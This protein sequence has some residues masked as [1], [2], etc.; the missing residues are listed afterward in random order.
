MNRLLVVLALVA[1]TMAAAPADSSRDRERHR[2]AGVDEAVQRAVSQIN[3]RHQG[4]VLSAQPIDGNGS[5]KVRVKFLSKDGVI[6]TF[7]VEPGDG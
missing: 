2:G 5:V 7:V 4:R 3:K 1:A 6:K